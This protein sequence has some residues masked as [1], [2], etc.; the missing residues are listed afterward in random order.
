MPLTL[1]DFAESWGIAGL[2]VLQ[3][4]DLLV[5]LS[6]D[7]LSVAAVNAIWTQII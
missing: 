5:R 4:I 1:S 6:Q 3:I 2:T 7:L